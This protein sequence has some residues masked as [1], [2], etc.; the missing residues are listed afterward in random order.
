MSDW[1]AG[2]FGFALMTAYWPGISGVASTSRWDVAVL[3]VL[4]LFFAPRIRMTAVHWI[5]LALLIWMGLTLIWNDGWRDGVMDGIENESELM[6]VLAAFMVGSNLSGIRP[7]LIG[8]AL[9]IGVNS[10]VAIAQYCG[11]D[12][13]G[14]IQVRD[15]G[16]PAGLFYEKDRLAAAA[17]MVVVG[18]FRPQLWR[19]WLWLPLLLPS[20]VLTNSKAAWLAVFVS[21]L[22]MMDGW[23]VLAVSCCAAA[24]GAYVWMI[25]GLGLSG[26]ER[27]AI[28]QDTVANLNFFGHG[29]G[30]FREDFIRFANAYDF[31]YWQSRPEAP[32]NE[33]LWL[34]FE[35]GIPAFCLSLLLAAVLWVASVDRNQRGML[36]CLAVLACFA[37]PFHDPATVV[38][39]A[40]V[41]GSVAG[42]PVGVLDIA[43]DRGMAVR[44]WMATDA[45]HRKHRAFIDSEEG[46]PVPAEIS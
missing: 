38:L 30:S 29:L 14:I 16:S 18:V 44:P 10:A 24:C 37:M 40:I 19:S 42:R 39:G 17:A 5:G 3:L 9:G 46:I 7:I 20:L 32:H 36:V 8:A 23:L 34:A 27:L 1:L 25:H 33:W 22:V 21:Y 28:W 11:W 13:F 4:P 43:V 12:G 26:L 45:D 6:I 15:A 2:A 35:G 31:S 41:A